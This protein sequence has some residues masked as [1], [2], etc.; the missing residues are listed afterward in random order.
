M[1]RPRAYAW[2]P[3]A[4]GVPLACVRSVNDSSSAAA[5]SAESHR[6]AA[7]INSGWAIP[8]RNRSPAAT[9]LRASANATG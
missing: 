1:T 2:T 4:H 3:S 7:S 5:M 8:V 6:I 9:A